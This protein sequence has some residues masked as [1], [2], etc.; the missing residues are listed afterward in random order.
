VRPAVAEMIVKIDELGLIGLLDG[1]KIFIKM[2][3]DC[4][5]KTIK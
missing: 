2:L 3:N 5:P 1:A 4:N